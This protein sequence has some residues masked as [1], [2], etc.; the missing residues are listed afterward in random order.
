MQ[1]LL[2]DWKRKSV[3][4]NNKRT[5]NANLNSIFSVLQRKVRYSKNSFV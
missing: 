2:G 1:L 5:T 3:K 4:K